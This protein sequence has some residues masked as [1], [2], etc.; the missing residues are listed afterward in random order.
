MGYDP[1][2]IKEKYDE[3]QT[4]N[5]LNALE[6]ELFSDFINGDT[7]AKE[8]N[9]SE[10][11]ELKEIKN[12]SD[13]KTLQGL[14]DKLEKLKKKQLSTEPNKS[15]RL[16]LGYTKVAWKVI[17]Q[18]TK[19]M[20]PY[21]N[22]LITEYMSD[23]IVRDIQDREG[24]AATEIFNKYDLK[25]KVFVRSNIIGRYPGSDTGKN[26]TQTRERLLGL[27]G[28]KINEILDDKSD[29]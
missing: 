7:E 24:E 13:V 25:W 20:D 14:A 6:E 21:I 1:K 23:L 12:Y 4:A 17:V 9:T 11:P 5:P 15:R 22:K 27:F 10:E 8:V 19:K 18:L 26:V 16:E 3:F 28:Y 2:E 29:N